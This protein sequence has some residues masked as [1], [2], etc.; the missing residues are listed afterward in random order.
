MADKS[1]P[2]AANIPPG[3]RVYAV[4]DIHGRLDLLDELLRM[5]ERD[6]AAHP[7]AQ[8]QLVFLGDYVDRGS[9]SKKVID[10]LLHGLPDGFETVFLQG[11]HE[12]T[13]L[14]VALNGLQDMG[15]F[16]MWTTYGGCETLASYG[17]DEKLLFGAMRNSLSTSDR[18]HIVEQFKAA[19]SDRHLSFLSELKIS[20]AVGDYFFVHAGVRPG[21][22]LHEQT[23]DDCLWIRDTFLRYTGDFGK[24]VVHGHTPRPEPDVKPNR[25][26][27]DTGAYRSGRLTALC[28]E[29][30]SRRFLAT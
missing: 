10:R 26:G 17:V 2:H 23:P 6:N 11:N 21:M 14:F 29:G 4:G 3:M 7:P 24:I 30:E 19:L 27:I 20:H 28:L 18:Q 13:M 25:I 8:A 16:E 1:A 22:A 15:I 9:D 12:A 5:I